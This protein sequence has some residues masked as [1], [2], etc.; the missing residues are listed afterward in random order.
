M[1]TPTMELALKYF[2]G[3]ELRSQDNRGN[4]SGYDAGLAKVE[5]GFTAAHLLDEKN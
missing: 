1:K 5:L 2:P 3:V 4:W